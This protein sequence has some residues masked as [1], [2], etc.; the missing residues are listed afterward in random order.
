M[1]TPR[2]IVG[3]EPQSVENVYLPE[4]AGIHPVE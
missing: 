4:P 3:P 2:P 1:S